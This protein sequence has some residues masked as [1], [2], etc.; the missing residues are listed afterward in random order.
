MNV[1]L[2]YEL[3]SPKKSHVRHLEQRKFPSQFSARN[4]DFALLRE[5]LHGAGMNVKTQTDA[6]VKV[7]ASTWFYP[8]EPGQNEPKVQ[9]SLGNG[10]AK[11]Q[12][13]QDAIECLHF[14]I[15]G[16]YSIPTAT[17][18]RRSFCSFIH[19]QN[20]KNATLSEEVDPL[21]R[22]LPVLASCEQPRERYIGSEKI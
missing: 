2:L 13:H 8:V 12:K 5:E 6:L 22:P 4:Q 18:P 15:L 3:N 1:S 17:P 10:K 9:V 14:E 16:S 7:V 20:H 11:Q 21:L 19:F